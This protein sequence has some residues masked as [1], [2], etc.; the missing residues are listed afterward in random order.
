MYV[1]LTHGWTLGFLPCFSYCEYAAMNMSAQMSL[2]IP[3]VNSFQLYTHSGIVG[4]HCNFVFNFWRNYRIVFHS[5]CIIWHFQQQCRSFP[6]C[7]HPCH[8]YVLVFLI[9]AIPIGV[10]WYL[11]VVL[12]CISLMISDIE[13]LFTWLLAISISTLETVYLSP[14]PTF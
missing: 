3:V 12:V 8:K 13:H 10:K 9:V 11:T 2:Q 14:L 6:V 1:T 7:S 5:N 4:S